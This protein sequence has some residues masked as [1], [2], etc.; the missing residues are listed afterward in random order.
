MRALRRRSVTGLSGEDV[1][2]DLCRIA[3]HDKAKVVHVLLRGALHVGGCDCAQLFQ[4]EQRVVPAAANQFVLRQLGSLRGIRLLA[5]VVGGEKLR[6]HRGDIVLID[7]FVLKPVAKVYSVILPE[8]TASQA[9]ARRL[10]FTLWEQRV[11]SHFPETEHGIWR[12][13][14]ART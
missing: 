7:R 6:D 5:H 9:V 8:N 13:Q 14:R 2:V 1:L 12:L 10:G 4:K 11:L 3:K